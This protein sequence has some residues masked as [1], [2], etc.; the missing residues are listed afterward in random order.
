MPEPE[1]YVGIWNVEGTTEVSER[2]RQQERTEVVLGVC[3]L[4]VATCWLLVHA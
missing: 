4:V 1:T 2:C 3:V